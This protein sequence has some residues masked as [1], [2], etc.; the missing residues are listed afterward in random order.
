MT[1][2]SI[3]G[4]SIDTTALKTALAAAWTFGIGETADITTLNSLVHAINSDLIVSS[5]GV[6]RT[7]G[8]YTNSIAPTSKLNYFTLAVANI[9][10]TT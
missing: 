1:V 3:S 2:T 7:A 6:S 5:E 4:G 9:T 8:S 10:V